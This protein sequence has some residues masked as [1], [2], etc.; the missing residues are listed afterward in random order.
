VIQRP[1]GPGAKLQPNYPE[2]NKED[3]KKV[4]N[5]EKEGEFGPRII[6]K[7]YPTCE[8]NWKEPGGNKKEPRYGA[9][10]LQP[11]KMEL[12]LTRQKGRKTSKVAKF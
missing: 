4:P 12:T 1:K 10:G 9:Q 7:I 5:Q 11:P 6:R 3:L 8:P 2:K